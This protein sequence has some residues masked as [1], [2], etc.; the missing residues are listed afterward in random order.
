[1]RASIL[2][3]VLVLASGISGAARAQP[4]SPAQHVSLLLALDGKSLASAAM[5]RS[6]PV[7]TG[8]APDAAQRD[9]AAIG[10][11]EEIVRN[12]VIP[13]YV[14]PDTVRQP[15]H[16]IYVTPFAPYY[17]AYGLSLNFEPRAL[18]LH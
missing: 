17:G 18:L 5:R 9:A 2:S 6:N 16:Q 13:H 10:H 1:M 8:V 15:I 11:A 14:V 12:V 4:P 7:V 3:A